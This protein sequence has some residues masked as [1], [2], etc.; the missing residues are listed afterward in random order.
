MVTEAGSTDKQIIEI[1][2]AFNT[3]SGLQ[4]FNTLSSTWDTI[5]LSSFT[6]STPTTRTI[7]GNTVNYNRYT[8]NGAIIGARQLRFLV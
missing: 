3:I 7:Q 6:P 2:D 5:L 8:H 1:P 4:Q